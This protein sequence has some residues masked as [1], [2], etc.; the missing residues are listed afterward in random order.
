MLYVDAP[1]L[2]NYDSL[3]TFTD[4]P[5]YYD[6]YDLLDAGGLPKLIMVDYRTNTRDLILQYEVVVKRYYFMGE[7]VWAL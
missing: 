5:A 1:Y 4:K 6:T 7:F 2:K 3:D